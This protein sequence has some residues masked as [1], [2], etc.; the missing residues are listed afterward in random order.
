MERL[1]EQ[2]GRGANF[3]AVARQF[4]QSATAAVGGDLGWV[5]QGALEPELEKAAAKLKVGELSEPVRTIA[6]YHLLAMRERRDSGKPTVD[7]TQL[8]LEHLF[9]P[10]PPN[11]KPEELAPLRTLAQTVSDNA[12]NCAEFAKL[13]KELPDAKVV[14]PATIVASE[15]A[16][17][18]REAAQKL[19]IKTKFVV[20]HDV[21]V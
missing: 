4:S 20:R 15:L 1:A 8:A 18:L 17:A 9:L 12:T 7:T 14:L 11:A 16:P 21:E 2:I 5:Q 6:G 3:T 10:G 13:R 19:P